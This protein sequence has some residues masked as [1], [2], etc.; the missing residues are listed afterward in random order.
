MPGQ[1]EG[2]ELQA[3]VRKLNDFPP[4]DPPVY[5]MHSIIALETSGN[6][7]AM[8]TSRQRPQNDNESEGE[9]VGFP[10]EKQM[11]HSYHEDLGRGYV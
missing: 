11:A 1:W 5:S 3:T 6:V 9:S 10:V 4:K 8:G 2:V 7:I